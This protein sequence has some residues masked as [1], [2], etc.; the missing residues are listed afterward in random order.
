MGVHS[1]REEGERE[2]E[3]Q[4]NKPPKAATRCF[5]HYDEMLAQR[6][7]LAWDC[8]VLAATYSDPKSLHVWDACFSLRLQLLWVHQIGDAGLRTIIRLGGLG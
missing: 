7:L 4:G 1:R 6:N 2:R 8:W 5:D 3:R